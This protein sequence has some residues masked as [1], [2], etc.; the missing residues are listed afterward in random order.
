MTVPNARFTEL[1]QDIE[2]SSTTKSHASTAHIK[3][4][5]HLRTQSDFKDLYTGSFLSG[6]SARDTALRPRTSAGQVER[7]DI[8]IIVV[9]DFSTDDDPEWVLKKVC[10]AIEDKGI[11][12]PVER[13]N[14]RSVRVNTWR[15]EMDIVPVVEDGTEGYW[16]ADRESGTWQFTNPPVHKT[17]SAE[18]N[19][20]F[21]GRFTPM[22]K[23]FKWWRRINPTSGKR[24]KGFVLERL[25]SLHA[26]VGEAHY[27]EAFTQLLENIQSA[28]EIN[29]A[30]GMK[31]F[32]SDPAVPG[33]DI[34]SRVTVAQW[35]EFIRKVATYAA[36]ARKAQDAD[37]LDEATRQWRRV[38]GDRFKTTQKTKASASAFGTFATATPAP[39]Y[40]FP[41]AMAAP[42]TK[43]RG[44]A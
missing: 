6:S 2:P 27:G 30:L 21:N 8:D 5:E 20:I 10:R 3:M 31:P 24:P 1:L 19:A 4:R 36:I 7:P 38:L 18:Q 9:T 12:Y 44:F 22:V 25:V 26:P 23:L 41:D 43:P 28:Y 13:M 14:R 11:G 34:L 35:Q 15:A 42:T 33:N 39:G 17:W 29:A 16:I 40:S 32:I 37:D